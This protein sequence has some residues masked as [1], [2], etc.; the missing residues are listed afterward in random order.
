MINFNIKY[1]YFKIK[2]QSLSGVC[3][4]E[5]ND[6]CNWKNSNESDFDWLINR[7]PTGTPQTGPNADHTLGTFKGFKKI[8]RKIFL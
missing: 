8:L 6:F 2:K 3:D 7:G 4:F 1:L 5:N